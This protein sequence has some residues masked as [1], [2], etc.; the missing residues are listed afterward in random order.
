MGCLYLST[1]AVLFLS[2]FV[3][4]CL[5]V[6]LTL[7]GDQTKRMI[8]SEWSYRHPALRNRPTDVFRQT[9]CSVHAFGTR[10]AVKGKRFHSVYFER[11]YLYGLLLHV[12]P[13]ESVWRGDKPTPK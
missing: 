10:V 5:D 12:S 1:V 11:K 13:P 2:S 4:T 8:Y 9:I 6:L 3:L 7:H